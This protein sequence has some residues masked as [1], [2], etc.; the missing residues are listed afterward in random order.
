M[1]RGRDRRLQPRHH[2]LDLVH[3]LDRVGARLRAR[4][5]AA[6]SACRRTRRRCAA[7]STASMTSADILRARPARRCDRPT[8]T[9]R[10]AL[11][12][13]SWSLVSSVNVLV[14]AFQVA[15]RQVGRGVDQRGAHVLQA[16]AAR[17]QR[18]GVHLH[19]HRR[20]LL[21]G[22]VDLRHAAHPRERL[23]QHVVGV[24][25]ESVDR[26]RVGADRVDQDR[27]GWPGWSCGKVG[28]WAGSSAAA[29][30]AALIAVCTS[31][32]G[33]VDVARQVELQRDRGRAE[34]A[35]RGHLGEAGD[36]GEL[37][38][39]RR[40]DRGGHGVRAGAGQLWR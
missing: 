8:M 22:D 18:V 17:G 3:H 2:R 27:R 20:D 33:A 32:R 24:L 40:G 6:R 26:H 13:N 39:Q 25:V 1:H 11:A 37:L 30:S 7:I 38:L 31:L 19:V 35:G 12:S 23:R 9:W 36:G 34:A 15:L 21:A 5:A 29:R 4:S 10:N 28:G 14:R 16:D